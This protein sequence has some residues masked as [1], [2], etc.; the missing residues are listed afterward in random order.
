[1]YPSLPE[2]KKFN[3]YQVSWGLSMGCLEKYGKGFLILQIKEK[4]II[5]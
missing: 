1:M 4:I 5:V 2:K 3:H